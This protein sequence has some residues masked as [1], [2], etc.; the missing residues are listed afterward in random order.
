[1]PTPGEEV[2]ALDGPRLL[3]RDES[4]LDRARPAVHVTLLTRPML[5]L[6]VAQPPGTPAE[7]RARARGFDI[8]RRSTGGTGVLGLPGDLAWTVVL[9]RDDPR[10]GPDHLRAYG[11]L[12][13]APARLL[14]GPGRPV[15]WRCVPALH[16]ELCFLSGRGEVLTAHGRVLG[17]AAQHRTARALLHHGLLVARVPR[18]EIGAIYGL[19]ESEVAG[20]LTG[21]DELGLPDPPATLGVRLEEELSRGFGIPRPAAPPE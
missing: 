13:G 12:G 6:G 7:E 14:S 1:M 20:A 9:P 5:S 19:T 15:R 4:A 21:L 18:E 10:L 3:A 11:R 17:G 16:P 8:V 2:A